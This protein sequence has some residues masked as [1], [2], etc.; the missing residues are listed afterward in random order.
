MPG[1]K[2]VIWEKST[3]CNIFDRQFIYHTYLSSSMSDDDDDGDNIIV[4]KIINFLPYFDICA[5]TGYAL[6][7]IHC[8]KLYGINPF[9]VNCI[10]S[11]S[12]VSQIFWEK[13]HFP[14][15][16][17]GNFENSHLN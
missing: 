12:K 6:I 10:G 17:I 2:L 8:L 16:I 14:T 5:I 3:L 4:N 11:Y 1:N 13:S 7:Q 15:R 9:F